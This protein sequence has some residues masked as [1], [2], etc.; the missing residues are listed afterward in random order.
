MGYWSF[1][2]LGIPISALQGS[3]DGESIVFLLGFQ[4]IFCIA[5]LVGVLG[6]ASHMLCVTSGLEESLRVSLK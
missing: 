6:T 1:T 2:A 4:Q 3:G 5:V